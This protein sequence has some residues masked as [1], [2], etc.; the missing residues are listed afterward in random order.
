M[1]F[2]ILAIYFSLVIFS[3]QIYI[4]LSVFVFN[5][6]TKRV[7]YICK[8]FGNNSNYQLERLSEYTLGVRETRSKKVEMKVYKLISPINIAI[9]YSNLVNDSLIGLRESK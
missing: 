8:G 9:Y 6:F 4:I 5:F 7:Q 1:F 3:V 2:T